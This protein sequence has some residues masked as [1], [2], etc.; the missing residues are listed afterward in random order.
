L[1]RLIEIRPAQ[2]ADPQDWLSLWRGYCAELDGRVSDEATKGLWQRIL[3]PGAPVDSLLAVSPEGGHVWFA[4]YVLHAHT[5]SLRPVCYLEDLLVASAARGEGGERNLD[6]GEV[7][8]QDIGPIGLQDRIVA[9]P[10]NARWHGYL[11]GPLLLQLSRAPS[12]S[13]ES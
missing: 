2:A 7:L 5:W 1:L 11:R 12:S 3:S 10:K 6:F 8:V 13:P 4:N 9:A